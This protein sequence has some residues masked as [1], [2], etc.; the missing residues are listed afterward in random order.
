[1]TALE[2]N[3]IPEAMLSGRNQQ[4]NREL[5]TSKSQNRI[6]ARN[7]FVVDQTSTIQSNTN[8]NNVGKS[9]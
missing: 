8:D 9:R 5:L 6:G 7:N 4:K 3:S 1:M 2:V